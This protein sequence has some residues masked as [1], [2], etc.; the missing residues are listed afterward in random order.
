MSAVEGLFA[1]GR[2]ID[3]TETAL[4]FDKTTG[5]WTALGNAEDYRRSQE[6]NDIITYQNCMAQ[7]G[8]W[9]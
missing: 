5:L 6:R 3:E 8:Y 2:D 7:Y 1:T 9:P 4:H